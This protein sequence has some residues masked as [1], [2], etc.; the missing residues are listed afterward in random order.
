MIHLGPGEFFGEML[1]VRRFGPFAITASRYRAGER[2]PRHCHE[3]PYLYVM[4]AGAMA[5]HALRRENVCTR[6]WLVY[7]EVGEGHEDQVF[8]HGAEGLNIEIASDW[9]VCLRDTGVAY[10]PLLYRHA[11]PAITTVGVL[12][13]AL[14]SADPLQ[15]LGAEEAISC[16]INALCFPIQL[17]R[18]P[19]AW[20]FRAEELIRSLPSGSFRL[21]DV[22]H[23]AGVHP[24][25]LCR[26]FHRTFGCTMTRYVA[27][28]R[29]D[30]ALGEV[31]CSDT[32]L[33]LVA[34]RSGF[35][36][37]AHLTRAI[38]RHFSTTPGQ[39]RREHI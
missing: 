21:D 8:D 38:R 13:L 10:E 25:H 32:P 7:N 5:E 14:R 34:A 2:L 28:L 39:L 9:L 6:G 36:D 33:A 31:L 1:G 19:P 37:Q 18:C 20:L 27:Q 16:L 22:A 4:L 26:E 11:G 23:A 17:S 29:A 24:A 12:Q 30:R 3:Q 35:S 15:G